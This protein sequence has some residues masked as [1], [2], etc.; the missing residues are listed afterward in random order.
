M[1]RL[2]VGRYATPEA[3]EYYLDVMQGYSEAKCMARVVEIARRVCPDSVGEF[4]AL[5]PA[6]VALNVPQRRG[7]EEM[8]DVVRMVRD[9]LP[10]VPL[11]DIMDA[12]AGT[13]S[14]LSASQCAK[15]A[16]QVL[17]RQTQEPEFSQVQ[18]PK[19]RLGD[20]SHCRGD[21]LRW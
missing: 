11:K 7:S 9:V 1:T 4:E 15:D 10:N 20:A 13:L 6:Q 17:I 8:T 5:L 19:Y 3:F 18:C 2:E 16:V 12:V 21:G 14:V